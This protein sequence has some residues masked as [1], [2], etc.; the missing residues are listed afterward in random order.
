[1]KVKK[2]PV[3]IIGIVVFLIILCGIG[4][5]FYQQKSSQTKTYDNFP[6]WLLRDGKVAVYQE[7]SVSPDKYERKVVVNNLSEEN[8]KGVKVYV[9]IPKEIAQKASDVTFSSDVE[10]I[11][12]DPVVL[13]SVGNPG[14]KSS[15]MSWTDTALFLPRAAGLVLTWSRNIA[16]NNLADTCKTATA[17][18][19][20]E[21]NTWQKDKT[22][23]L[24]CGEYIEHIEKVIQERTASD[25]QNKMDENKVITSIDST[26]SQYKEIKTKAKEIIRKNQAQPSPTKST[27]KISKEEAIEAV[28]KQYPKPLGAQVDAGWPAADCKPNDATYIESE[29]KWHVICI[30]PQ[31]EVGD[32]A[33]NAICE[34]QWFFFSVDNSGK[35]I[36][37]GWYDKCRLKKDGS[38]ST[39]GKPMWGVK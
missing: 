1:M 17:K 16:M 27:Q 30:R 32:I 21:K 13:W 18:E 12:D 11:K 5:Y 28:K 34:A 6:I 35:A 39:Y 14:E 24:A 26:N 37:E 22:S 33:H 7:V 2:L 4:Y 23:F 38:L 9:E 36:E 19:W 8:Q 20:I 10:I 15:E 31:H 25:W 29:Q 3:K